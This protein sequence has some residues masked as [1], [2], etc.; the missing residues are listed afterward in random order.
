MRTPRLRDSVIVKILLMGLLMLLLLIPLGMVTGLVHERESRRDEALSEVSS[1]WG[2]SQQITGPVLAVPYRSY[3]IDA[4]KTVREKIELAYFLPESVDTA[5]SIDPEKRSRGLY[6][7]VLYSIKG[8]H[9]SGL[10]SRPDFSKLRIAEKNVFWNDAFIFVGISDT[11]AIQKEIKLTFGKRTI[12]F[13]PGVK[14]AGFISSGIHAG[15][16]S[17]KDCTGKP[18]PFSF[19]L[20]LK[21]NSSL[22]FA[23]SGKE[24][25]VS[26]FSTWQHPSFYGSYLPSEREITKDGF[27]A[28]WKVSYFGRNSPQ[29]WTDSSSKKE[30]LFT[31]SGFGVMLYQP[32]D[33]YQKCMRAVKYGALFIILT[34]LTFFLFEIFSRLRIHPLQYLFIGFAMCVFYLLF[35]SISEHTSF[36]VS[37]LVSSAATVSM[38]TGYSMAILRERRRGGIIAGLLVCLYGYM[39]TLLQNQDYAL[40]LGALALFLVLALVMYITRNIDWY[41]IQL[42]GNGSSGSAENSG[43]AVE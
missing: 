13:S 23:A 28:R 31:S 42:S 2:H 17:L 8:M 12:P 15:T 14:T 10:F 43:A 38:I 18:I 6:E 4:Q 41:S 26:L 39:F 16:G 36:L 9:V 27:S 5:A 3:F 11:R 22:A 25:N 1:K 21:G 29:E 24:T 20:D 37:Y 19:S 32:V 35:L 40:L 33:F 30:S 34:F 7:V